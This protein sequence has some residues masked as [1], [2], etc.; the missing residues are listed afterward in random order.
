MPP[1]G[2]LQSS[3]TEPLENQSLN[4]QNADKLNNNPPP[5]KK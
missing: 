4:G 2:L 5:I 3:E 1:D